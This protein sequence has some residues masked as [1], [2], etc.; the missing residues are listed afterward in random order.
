MTLRKEVGPSKNARKYMLTGLAYCGR[1]GTPLNG[2]RKMDR[3]SKPFL[4][5]YQCRG[6]SDTGLTK[7]CRGV[8]RNGEA[9]EH[10]VAECVFHRLDTPEPAPYSPEP[11]TPSTSGAC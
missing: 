1:C 4:R 3:P 5:T 7:G 9:L 8:R 6:D 10:F 2:C 11:S